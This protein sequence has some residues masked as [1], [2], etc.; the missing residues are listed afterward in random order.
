MKKTEEQEKDFVQFLDGYKKL[1]IKVAGIYCQ[2]TEERKDL[3]QEI[4]LQLWKAWPTYNPKYALSTWTYR[5]ALNVSISH[6][7]K[8]KS[9]QVKHEQYGH[10]WE[11]LHWQNDKLDQQLEQLYKM[12]E[13]LKPMDKALL[14]LSLEGNKNKEIAEVLG[15]STSNVSTKLLRIKEQLRK[16]IQSSKN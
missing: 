15:I 7:R 11:V 8:E 6:L 9:R 2:Q 3:T 12:M 14:I 16:Q 10:Q 4:I 13:M 5:I 1:I